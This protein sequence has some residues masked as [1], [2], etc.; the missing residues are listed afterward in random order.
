MGI[1]TLDIERLN[2]TT[3]NIYEMITILSKRSRQISADEKIEL[4]E[5][6]RYFEGYDEEEDLRMNEE[7]EKICKI[8]EERPHATQ[9]AVEEMENDKISYRRPEY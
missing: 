8:F 5:K 2:Q 6:L 9:R 3:G 4:D 1:K 7:Q